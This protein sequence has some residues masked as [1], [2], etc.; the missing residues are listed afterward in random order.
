ML[1]LLKYRQ[2]V[3][4]NHAIDARMLQKLILPEKISY[5]LSYNLQTSSKK[6][7]LFTS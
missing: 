7:T 5:A 6:I 2:K 3:H 4:L 1:L